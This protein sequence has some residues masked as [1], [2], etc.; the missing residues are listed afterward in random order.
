MTTAQK[1]QRILELDKEAMPGPWARERSSVILGEDPKNPGDDIYI[2]VG[3]KDAPFIA[4]TRTLAPQV[5]ARYLE[6][7]ELLKEVSQLFTRVTDESVPFDQQH[8]MF[9]KIE[10]FLADDNGGSDA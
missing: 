4:E 6:A 2:D 5:A 10:R 8:E 9:V 3:N 7:V 1:A